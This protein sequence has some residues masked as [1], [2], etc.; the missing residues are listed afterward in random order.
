MNFFLSMKL[1]LLCS[2]MQYPSKSY[3]R[4][5]LHMAKCGHNH[6]IVRALEDHPKA[7]PWTIEIELCVVKGLPG[8]WTLHIPCELT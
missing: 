3:F 7:I 4:A 8:G 5:T 2:H 1:V 6:G